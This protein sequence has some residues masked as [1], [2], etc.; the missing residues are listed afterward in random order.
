MSTINDPVWVRLTDKGRE[1]LQADWDEWLAS[2]HPG[3]AKVFDKD[4]LTG[5]CI[6]ER[7]DGWSRWQ[8]WDL[9]STFGE[10]VYP[11]AQTPFETEIRLTEPE[12]K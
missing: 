2:L 10:H 12:G 9:M 7:D 1:Q 3:A 4:A 8:L 6:T 11:G 5:K